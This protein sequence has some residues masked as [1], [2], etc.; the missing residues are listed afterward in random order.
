M[1]TVSEMGSSVPA[2]LG[3]LWRL[4]EDPETDDLICWAPNGRSFFIRNQAQ[5]ARELLPHYYKH[6][7]MASFVRQLNMYGFHKKVSVELGGLKC[8]RDEM[9]FA[10]QYFCKDHPY[11]L[12][13]IKRKIASNKTQ[14][15]SQTPMKPEL[16]NRMLTEV[17]SLRGRQEHFDSRLGA[18]KRENE[19]LWRELALL[20]QKHHKQQQIVNKLIHFLVSLVQP[21]RNG[22]LSMKRRY[23]LMIDDSDRER[24]RQSKM[25]K[26]RQ[27]PSGPA[28]H[29]LDASD[30]DLDSE[31]IVAEMLDNDNTPTIESPEHNSVTDD[32]SN[33]YYVDEP[34][35]LLQEIDVEQ[36]KVNNLRR[37]LKGKRTGRKSKVP[38][39]ILIPS[40][41]NG[42]ETREETLL[43]EVSGKPESVLNTTTR[44]STSSVSTTQ[45]IPLKEIKTS[46]SSSKPVPAATVRSSKLA[47][48]AANMKKAQ[49]VDLD[50]DL[51]LLQDSESNNKLSKNNSAIKL[52]NILI[53]PDIVS[54]EYEGDSEGNTCRTLS[55][56][57]S[58]LS[59]H[60]N[61][62]Q[63]SPEAVAGSS[64]EAAGNSSP[65][66]TDFGNENYGTF[67]YNPNESPSASDRQQVQQQD[68]QTSSNKQNES[69]NMTLSCVNQN[70]SMSEANYREEVDTHLDSMQSELENLREILRS[71]GY[72]ID[73]NTL[74]GLFGAEDPMS[75]GIPVNPD[76]DPHSNH[77][78]DLVNNVQ[79]DSSCP[80]NKG[81][82]M[83]YNSTP[84]LLD[85]DDDMFLGTPSS[86]PPTAPTVTD[87][88]NGYSNNDALN[89]VDDKSN[90]FD[91]LIA[92]ASNPSP[93]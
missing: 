42:G 72:S 75:F 90:I 3:K 8:D 32:S 15:P 4:V 79:V 82:L 71:E 52:E 74:L 78:K 44:A 48:M 56:R 39:K 73:A 43:L 46:S 92:N 58:S 1:H 13:H 65:E 68:Q 89:H 27:S 11:L 20:R 38:I 18:M 9:E 12:D 76:L 62:A 16:M 66:S 31:Y 22:G 91:S 25:S 86:S 14:D 10:H 49:E 7:N 21:N 17:R 37:R 5:F 19:A 77:D 23:P 81:E 33:E 55:S 34:A 2:F 63:S 69:R 28:I 29:E 53:V 30:P 26:V 47:A 51:D 85:F 84:S 88:T 83:T 6:N 35:Q 45:K 40:S 50:L 64:P 93:T 57:A 70:G 59:A 36:H 41:E 87:V 24:L 67:G 61:A 80:T 54:E 60:S